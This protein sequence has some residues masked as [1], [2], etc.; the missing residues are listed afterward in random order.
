MHLD[1]D[2]SRYYT[3]NP[4]LVEQDADG[5]RVILNPDTGK[6]VTFDP[7][8]AVIWEI[9]QSRNCFDDILDILGEGFAVEEDQLKADLVA[10]WNGLIKDQFLFIV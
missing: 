8:T 4:Q 3:V 5:D 6:I 9:M 2:F 10:F 7:L 1:F